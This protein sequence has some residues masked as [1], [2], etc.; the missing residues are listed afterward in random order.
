MGSH[1]DNINPIYVLIVC[2]CTKILD[3][4][5]SVIPAIPT[6]PSLNMPI[7]HTIVVR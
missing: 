6:S 3:F 4:Y 2:L 7:Q 5:L 1:P